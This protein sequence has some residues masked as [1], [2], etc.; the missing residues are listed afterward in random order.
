M[1]EIC[2]TLGLGVLPEVLR[3]L[4]IESRTGDL[5][6]A[7]GADRC[8][9]HFCE[10]LIAD[11]ETT[12]SGAQL[13]DVLVQ[14]GYL[15][16]GD[17]A[18]CL[19]LGSISH[20]RMSGTLIRHSLLDQ[21]QLAQGLL[22]QVREVLARLL[23][24][25]GGGYTFADALVPKQDWGLLLPR[26]DPRVGMLDAVWTLV[27]DPIVDQ[28]M[29]P[30]GQKIQR[31][32]VAR[33]SGD[34]LT[35]NPTDAF[36]LSRIDGSSTVGQIL[37]M[38]PAPED[39]TKASLVGLICA[40]AVSVEGAPAPRSATAEIHRSEMVRLAG[41]LHAADPHEVLGVKTGARTEDIRSNYLNLL[42][43]CDPASSNDQDM[44]PLLQRMTELLREAFQQV[45][46]LRASAR[47]VVNRPAPAASTGTTSPPPR[48]VIGPEPPQDPASR[49]DPER[50][51][52]LA[53]EAFEAGRVHEALALLHEAVPDLTGRARRTARVRL[54]R[55]LRATPNGARLALE[56][57][58]NAIADDPGNAEA[59]LLLGT[60]YREGG[61]HA[62]AVAAFKK[63]LSLDP[64]N[65]G[66]RVA[67]HELSPESSTGK[68]D[69]KSTAASSLLTK[70]F[71][72]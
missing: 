58:K 39:E 38:S 52:E 1:E 3:Q 49:V 53:D 37:Q 62:L 51:I 19:E 36:L 11:C 24:W 66:A 22:I 54:A 17:R 72:R 5:H 23:H 13:G 69:A 7:H 32:A 40:G 26:I 70:L 57:L 71:R 30:G 14:V 43:V 68:E 28:L 42:K 61:S 55:I 9:I 67:L 31:A 2:G 47:A 41:R 34:D 16:D 44:K 25:S 60:I 64:R 10:G 33:L 56:E 48:V 8:T 20:E 21:E 59:H 15:S 35:L 6:I 46:R 45:E 63:T 27:G 4:Y 50:A 29:G 65:G 18:V 12:L